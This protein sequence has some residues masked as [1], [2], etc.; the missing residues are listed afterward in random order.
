MYSLFIQGTIILIIIYFFQNIHFIFFKFKLMGKQEI[1]SGSNFKINLS[2]ASSNENKIIVHSD[3]E[4]NTPLSFVNNEET[5]KINKYRPLIK[6]VNQDRKN[7]DDSYSKSPTNL[8]EEHE[9][10][11]RIILASNSKKQSISYKNLI[12]KNSNYCGYFISEN[13]RDDETLINMHK[14]FSHDSNRIR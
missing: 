3:Q 1:T 12:L 6:S 11:N 4:A 8:L 13:F 9:S 10:L 7:N 2:K 5:S 14:S